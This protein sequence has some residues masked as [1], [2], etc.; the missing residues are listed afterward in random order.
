MASQKKK[1]SAKTS[2]KFKD[3]TSKKN[4]KGG[5]IVVCAPEAH[6]ENILIYPAAPI[7]RSRR[8]EIT[9]WQESFRASPPGDCVA[10]AFKEAAESCHWLSPCRSGL[11]GIRREKTD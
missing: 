9:K 10:I 1:A 5:I 2:A 4:P 7:G 3:L 8:E 6:L 11:H